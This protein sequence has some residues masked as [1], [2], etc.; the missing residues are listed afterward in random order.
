[1]VD[2][3]D[4]LVTSHSDKQNAA[5]TFQ[6]GFGFHPLTA[7]CNNTGEERWVGVAIQLRPGNA[8][9]NTAT[10]HIELIDR[11]IAHREPIAL[12]DQV[13]LFEQQD[14]HRYQAIATNTVGGH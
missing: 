13:W 4:T 11:A 3:D 10:D 8:G 9:S 1:M 14:G 5:P 7:W 6:E 2:L 12:A